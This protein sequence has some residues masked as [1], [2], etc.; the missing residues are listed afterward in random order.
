MGERPV[1]VR[2]EAL[3][4]LEMN[5]EDVFHSDGQVILDTSLGILMGEDHADKPAADSER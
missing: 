4:G 5:V 3:D 2:N 1:T